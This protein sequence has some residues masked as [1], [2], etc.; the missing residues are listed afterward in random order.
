[1]DEEV[2]EMWAA[3][4][5]SSRYVQGKGR[6]RY[7][8]KYCCL[9]VLCELA[10]KIGVRVDEG[11]DPNRPADTFNGNYAYPPQEVLDWAGLNLND[12]SINHPK[13]GERGISVLNDEFDVPFPE[14]AKL[15][16]EQL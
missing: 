1:M 5:E 10:V 16:R 14:L 13:Y 11:F 15:I 9:G 3:A 12:P 2:K 6:L 7:D 4:L 8:G